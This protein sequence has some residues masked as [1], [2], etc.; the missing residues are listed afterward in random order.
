MLVPR[1]VS[2]TCVYVACVVTIAYT[3]KRHAK[4]IRARV[5][6]RRFPGA[7]RFHS[8]FLSFHERSHGDFRFRTDL[9][10]SRCYDNFPL[11]PRWGAAKKNQGN[12]VV[13][14]THRSR[15]ALPCEKFS[16]SEFYRPLLIM[17]AVLIIH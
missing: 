14:C 16:V 7:R 15:F 11:V 17:Y 10:T 2:P 8:V 9:S 1:A 5:A 12:N 6:N 3:N 4:N 13:I